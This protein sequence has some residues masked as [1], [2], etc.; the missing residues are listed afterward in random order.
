VPS[1]LVD[2]VFDPFFSTK[3]GG[4]GLGLSIS[5]NIVAQHGGRLRFARGGNGSTR[6]LVTL[7][8]SERTTPE[9]TRWRT[10]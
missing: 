5:Q 8:R 7:P 6:A 4:T 3:Q 9:E 1:A 2:R 10:S